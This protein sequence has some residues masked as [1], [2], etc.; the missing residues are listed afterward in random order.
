MEVSNRCVVAA[1]LH[2]RG[3]VTSDDV[4]HS[5]AIPSASIK[6]DAIP[7]RINQIG[8]CFIRSGVFYGECRELCGI[9]HSFIPI[10]VEA[11]SVEVFTM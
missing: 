2:M 3:L 11:V 10:C 4:I 1:I 5:W 6:A 7:G 8:L 9:N